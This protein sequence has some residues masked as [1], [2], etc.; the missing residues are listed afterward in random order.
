MC[1][2]WYQSIEHNPVT[3]FIDL[4]FKEGSVGKLCEIF[5][6]FPERDPDGWGEGQPDL[7]RILGKACGSKDPL[8]CTNAAH[9]LLRVSSQLPAEEFAPLLED[10]LS[11]GNLGYSLEA[12]GLREEARRRLEECYAIIARNNAIMERRDE[13]TLL[14][15]ASRLP[16]AELRAQASERLIERSRELLP[17]IRMDILKGLV[18]ANL[19]D[20]KG[21][22][23]IAKQ[24]ADEIVSFC[25]EKKDG[26]LEG[27]RI[28]RISQ[29]HRFFTKLPYCTLMFGTHINELDAAKVSQ[30]PLATF[31]APLPR[32][33]P[34]V[35]KSSIGQPCSR[36]GSQNP[37]AASSPQKRI[38]RF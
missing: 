18:L 28:K 9:V 19:V 4:L 7:L 2:S 38:S 12:M 26:Q 6:S 1:T 11:L 35:R 29:A 17:L 27:E 34:R 31:N 21:Y 30:V 23:P 13:I 3:T 15:R 22:L 33:A 25:M 16:N 14:Q 37:S 32:R 10:I 36:N 8:V 20:N 5:N 24:A